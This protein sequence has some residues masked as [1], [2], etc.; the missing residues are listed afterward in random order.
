MR[1]AM[2]AALVLSGLVLASSLSIRMTKP[3]KKK[4]EGKQN[5]TSKAQELQDYIKSRAAQAQD[6]YRRVHADDSQEVAFVNFVRHGEDC[7]SQ[8]KYGLGGYGIRRAEYLARC[9]SQG[10]PSLI[11]PFGK[12]TALFAARVHHNS[13][14]RPIL[15]GEPLA[16]ATGLKLEAPCER[17]EDESSLRAFGQC[18]APHV[19]KSLVHGGTTNIYMT[20]H[21]MPDLVKALNVPLNASEN[22]FKAW[23]SAGKKC[24]S[25]TQTWGGEFCKSRDPDANPPGSKPKG[26]SCMDLIWQ[27]EFNRANSSAEWQAVKIIR[28]FQEFHGMDANQTCEGDMAPIPGAAAVEV[29]VRTA[30]VPPEE[31]SSEAVPLGSEE[32]ENLLSEDSILWDLDAE[33]G[34]ELASKKMRRKT[35]GESR[36]HRLQDIIDANI[37]VTE[38]EGSEQSEEELANDPEYQRLLK[39][40]G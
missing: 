6:T 12:P 37:V 26:I 29:P 17:S 32:A 5:A 25:M 40:Y 20:K 10:T 27:I 4:S 21:E 22:F 33:D 2:K 15:T 38:G 23:P 36:K 34:E 35:T 18:Q 11:L 19:L 9:M 7:K 30:L 3:K 13:S 39:M 31:A 14:F 1:V 16:N 8:K 24:R 28:L